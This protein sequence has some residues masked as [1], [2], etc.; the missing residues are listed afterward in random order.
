MEAKFLNISDKVRLKIGIES[1][2]KKS[3]NA[4]FD[5]IARLES[6]IRDYEIGIR[7]INIKFTDKTFKTP[8]LKF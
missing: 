8:N 7:Q 2:D 4:A 3:I 5:E 6:I 1:G